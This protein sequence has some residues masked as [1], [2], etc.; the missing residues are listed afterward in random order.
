MQAAL[1]THFVQYWLAIA[2]VSGPETAS[3]V[4]SGRFVRL[5]VPNK[6]VKFRD[7]RLN[8]SPEIRPEAVR[9]GILTAFVNLHKCRPEVAGDVIFGVTVE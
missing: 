4:I 6:F 9:G 2:F 7:P 5:T 1:F 3:D 8:R